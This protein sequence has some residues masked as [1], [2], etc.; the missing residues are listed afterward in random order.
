MNSQGPIKDYLK[1]YR[2][3]RHY[4]KAKYKISQDDLEMLFYL[5]SEVLFNVTMFIDYEK[6]FTRDKRRLTRL[7]DN[8]WIIEQPGIS[9]VRSKKIYALSIRAKN[10]IEALYSYLDG[11]KK[12]ET[13][14]KKNPLFRRKSSYRERKIGEEIIKL[15]RS[16]KG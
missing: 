13:D 7:M 4:A 6:T 1:Y 16:L 8:G 15:N 10:M 5:Y 2:V 14:P 9:R 3:V 11:S 12:L